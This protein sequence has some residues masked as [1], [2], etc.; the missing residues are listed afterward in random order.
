M[1]G[2]T[3][4]G[5]RAAS[6]ASK[7]VM[8]TV[9]NSRNALCLKGA[10]V[11]FVMKLPEARNPPIEQKQP[12][13]HGQAAQPPGTVKRRR[14]VSGAVLT[15]GNLRLH[16]PRNMRPEKASRNMCSV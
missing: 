16:Y 3:G 10:R 4:R 2:D 6:P 15:V 8:T 12:A 7:L 1:C 14:V 9:S 13:V 5:R 11:G